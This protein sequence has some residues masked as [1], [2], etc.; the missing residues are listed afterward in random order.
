MAQGFGFNHWVGIGEESTWGTAVSRTKWFEVLDDSI[1]LKQSLMPKSSLRLVSQA[2][3]LQSHQSVEGSLKFQ[4]GF[5]GYEKILKHAMGTLAAVSGVGPYTHAYT[6]SGT[7]QNGLTIESTHATDDIGAGNAFI[8][9]GCKFTKLTLSQDEEDFLM[10][11]A[12]VV[13]ETKNLGAK[14]TPTFPTFNGIDWS[15]VTAFTLSGV[16]I[17]D[18][19]KSFELTIDNGLAADRFKLGARTRK[20]PIR[21]TQRKIRLKVSVDYDAAAE[22]AYYLAQTTLIAV[23]ITWNN[24]LGGANNKQLQLALPAMA[25]QSPGATVSEPG[26][27]GLELEL[28]AFMNSA[29]HDEMTATLINNTSSSQ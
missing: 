11:T 12:D 2:R 9:E 17:L 21:G 27:L 29:E 16:S 8:F 1:E 18:I 13:G 22:Y 28:E 10:V 24:G 7:L 20:E 19:I 25:V 23:A 5:E 26:P 14:S 6:L 4:M 15:M 3:R